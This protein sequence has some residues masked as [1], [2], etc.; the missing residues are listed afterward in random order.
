VLAAVFFDV[1]GTLAETEARGHRV[2]YNMAFHDF[3]LAIEW[4][5]DLYGRLLAVTGGK[6]RVRAYLEEHPELPQ[7]DDDQLEALHEAKAKHFDALVASGAI[8]LRTGVRRLIDE[9]SDAGIPVSIATT[10]TMAA[11]DSLLSVNLGPDWRARFRDLGLGDVVTRKKPDPEV[12]QW[13]LAR[14]GLDARHV[15]AIE[16]S[17]NGLLAAYRAGIPTLVTPG[18]YTLEEDFSEAR[19]VADSLGDLDE[20]AHWRFD[21]GRTGSGLVDIELLASLVS[22]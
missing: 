10:S 20:P 17:R 15:V 21:D 1:D 16:D 9:L 2:A 14:Q 12:Y 13:L 19:V 8:P 3:G 6:E 5:H 7:L 22:E 18:E 4:D 11:V